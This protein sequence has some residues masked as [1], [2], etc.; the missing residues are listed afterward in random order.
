MLTVQLSFPSVVSWRLFLEQSSS[1][2]IET[3][4]ATLTAYIECSEEDF[5]GK[6]KEKAFGESQ[7][8]S[9]K[10]SGCFSPI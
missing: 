5:E 1:R 8:V 10:K 2:Y 9:I 6:N 7:V 3:H 4:P